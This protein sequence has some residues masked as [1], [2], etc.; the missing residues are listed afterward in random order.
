M[1]KNYYNSYSFLFNSNLNLIIAI[2]VLIFA[3]IHSITWYFLLPRI[4]PVKILGR[5]I[6]NEI[7]AIFIIILWMM[8][9][10][11]AVMFVY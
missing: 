1:G 9:V 4:Q 11:L 3:L 5:K 8:I 7:A 2:I 10:V 6:K